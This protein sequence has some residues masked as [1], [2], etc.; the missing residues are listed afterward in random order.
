[1]RLR[2]EGRSI[3]LVTKDLDEFMAEADDMILLAGGR[4]IAQGAPR[5]VVNKHGTKM[6]DLGV[7]LPETTEI[8]LRLKAAGKLKK[9]VPIT[10]EEA[11]DAFADA[12]FKSS[13]PSENTERKETVLIHAEDVEFMYGNKF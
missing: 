7:W 5:D 10:V 4:V 11:V 2:D 3:V 13:R 1:I 12:C 8:G 9:E 6:L